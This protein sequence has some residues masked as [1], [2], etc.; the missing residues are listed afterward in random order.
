MP[1]AERLNAEADGA[2]SPRLIPQMEVLMLNRSVRIR[3]V[4]AAALSGVLSAHAEP[5]PSS[6]PRLPLPVPPAACGGA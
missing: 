1:I 3:A 6:D 2:Y 4:E 5:S